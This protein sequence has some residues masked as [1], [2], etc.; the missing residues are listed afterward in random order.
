MVLTDGIDNSSRHRAEDVIARAKEGR[1]RLYML[2]FGRA[3]ELDAATMQKLAAETNGIYRHA[4]NEKELIELFKKLSIDL[5]D[6]GIDEEAL[7]R[8]SS[9]TKGKYQ[10]SKKLRD[11][12][13]IFQKLAQAVQSGYRLRFQGRQIA[14]G[15][16]RQIVIRVVEMTE[17]TRRDALGN[18]VHEMQE[19]NVSDEAGLRYVVRGVV[20]PQM[21]SLV[22][23]A[24]LAGLGLLIALPLV[25]RNL[26][27]PTADS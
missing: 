19:R 11:L 6:K 20:V 26:K 18:V 4:R 9:E 23:L 13:D 8:I 17:V 24:F 22:Y 2:G 16:A 10:H 21:H 14:D 5:D 27:R 1:V 3:N 15:T 25:L 7:K 12:N